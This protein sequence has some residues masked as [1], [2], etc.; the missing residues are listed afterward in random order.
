MQSIEGQEQY[1][2]WDLMRQCAFLHR[3]SSRLKICSLALPLCCLCV[4]ITTCSALFLLSYIYIPFFFLS[5]FFALGYVRPRLF[6]FLFF[7]VEGVS[8]V[9]AEWTEANRRVI[10]I[11]RGVWV[12]R[13]RSEEVAWRSGAASETQLWLRLR[14]PTDQCTAGLTTA[15]RGKGLFHSTTS[16]NHILYYSFPLMFYCTNGIARRSVQY[17]HSLRESKWDRVRERKRAF[18]VFKCCFSFSC[19]DFHSSLCA[20]I[21]FWCRDFNGSWCRLYTCDYTRCFLH[22]VHSVFLLTPP[23][24]VWH[25]FSLCAACIL[26]SARMIKFS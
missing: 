22:V 3:V 8:S 7:L 14:L 4:I 10:E 20:H 15:G 17:Y 23:I 11:W 13:C 25:L 26:I 9:K 6:F 24:I 5:F 1:D 21:F 16:E 12:A 18:G 19:F 2:I